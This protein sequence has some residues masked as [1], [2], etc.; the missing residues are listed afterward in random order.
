ML[1]TAVGM[2][3][4]VG[5]GAVIDSSI[6]RLERTELRVTDGFL[7]GKDVLG[8]DLSRAATDDVSHKPSDKGKDREDK[9]RDYADA[10]VL[11]MVSIW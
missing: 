3:G 6:L 11:A 8:C 2:A 7:P 5:K 9:N 1:S 10:T 4:M